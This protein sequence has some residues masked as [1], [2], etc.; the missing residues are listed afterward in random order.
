MVRTVGGERFLWRA[1]LDGE[2]EELISSPGPQLFLVDP[3]FVLG[4]L[5]YQG[6]LLEVLS[7]VLVDF[8]HFLA[9][10]KQLG[11]GLIGF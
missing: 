1:A 7:H 11:D 2:L 3:L 8:V 10:F 6:E 4:L 5:F 9:E